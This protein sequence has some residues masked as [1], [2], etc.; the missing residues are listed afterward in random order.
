MTLDLGLIKALV[1]IYMKKRFI[2]ANNFST[3]C[4]MEIKIAIQDNPKKK[5]RK[6]IS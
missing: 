2:W 4:E 6:N 5:T 1:T 3:E